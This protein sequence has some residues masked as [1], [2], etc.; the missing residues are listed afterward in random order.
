M[1][2][3]K[4]KPGRPKGNEPPSRKVC[5]TIPV[6]TLEEIDTE[7]GAI[8]RSRFLLRKAGYGYGATTYSR[9]AVCEMCLFSEGGCQPL[10]SIRVGTPYSADMHK[11][12]HINP[13]V[14][15]DS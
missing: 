9:K 7:R 14:R 6:K 13:S 2:D 1:T 12:T 3:S 10:S 4:R 11:S 15:G 8:D 5:I